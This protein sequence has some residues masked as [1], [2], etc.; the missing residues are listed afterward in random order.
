M[1][2]R[3]L[4]YFVEIVS[5]GSISKAADNLNVA[6]PALSQ[7]I[8]SLERELGV[9][10]LA[11]HA[12]GIR[13]SE[14]GRVLHQRALAILRDI[15]LTKELLAEVSDSPR[16]EIAVGL[17]TS[18]CR[19]LMLPLTQAVASRYPQISLHVVEAMSGTLEEW[20]STGRLDVA[21]SYVPF[22]DTNCA[23]NPIVESLHAIV[24]DLGLVADRRVIGFAEFASLPLVLPRRPN[25]IRVMADRWADALDVPLSVAI[26]CDSFPGLLQMVRQGYVALMPKFAVQTELDDGDLMAIDIVDPAPR[27]RI[28]SMVSPATE[29]PRAAALVSELMQGVIADMVETGQWKTH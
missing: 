17:P 14:A 2:L 4:R 3:Q 7:Q 11:R 27:W 18:A 24:A 22:E 5:A 16:A 8:R 10:L 6:Q 1:E 25:V 20:T 13:A 28:K 21:L 19:G 29:H 23:W 9:E 15:D 12:R 26:N